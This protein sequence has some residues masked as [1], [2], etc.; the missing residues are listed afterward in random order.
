MKK[1]IIQAQPKHKW[2]DLKGMVSYPLL[3]EDAQEW[4]LRTRW[5]GDEHRKGCQ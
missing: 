5:E 4:V 1:H 2:S 3:D